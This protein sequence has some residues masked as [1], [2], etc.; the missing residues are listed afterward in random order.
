MN[1]KMR[2]DSDSA[3][4]STVSRKLVEQKGQ[5]DEI[6]KELT[7]VRDVRQYGDGDDDAQENGQLQFQLKASKARINGLEADLRSQ[8]EK[9][10][11]LI[12]KSKVWVVMV[13]VMTDRMTIN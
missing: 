4:P 3:P 8:K 13:M 10:T 1:Q 12:T 7:A 9:I 6:Q 2:V 5:F 11:V